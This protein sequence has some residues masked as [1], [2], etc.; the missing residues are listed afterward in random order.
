MQDDD[1]F[2][3]DVPDLISVDDNDTSNPLELLVG[4]GKKF[5]TP[6]DLAKG[7]LESDRF[8]EQLKREQ[9]ELRQELNT[10]LSLEEFLDQ[11][12]ALS[13][14]QVPEVPTQTTRTENVE[15]LTKAEISAIVRDALTY[16]KTTASQ[17]EN[18]NYVRS[19]LINSWGPDYTKK[20]A[21]QAADLGVDKE[22]L[23][24]LAA[25]K[26]KAFLKLVQAQAPQAVDTTSVTPPRSS[27]RV[28]TNTSGMK[29]ETYYAKLRKSDPKT[30]F[31]PAV[32]AER[33]QMA[34]RLGTAFFD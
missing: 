17:A 29:N 6:E 28:N 4:E 14:T 23:N 24:N 12:K 31:S 26:P 2:G 7:K 20:L 15:S 33:H 10:R 21:A 13:N 19:E 22:F 18:M 30:Y 32:Q 5:K 9:A 1:I 27:V 16:E 34:Q 3:T 8:I 25:T 11:Q